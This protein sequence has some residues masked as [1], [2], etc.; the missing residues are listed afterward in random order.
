MRCTS[1]D[2]FHS[3]QC[4]CDKLWVVRRRQKGTWVFTYVYILCCWRP[5]VRKFERKL[6]ILAKQHNVGFHKNLF[7]CFQAV[8]REAKTNGYTWQIYR[9][10]F[11]DFLSNAQWVDPVDLLI[12]ASVLWGN[13]VDLLIRASVCEVTQ[14]TYW[15]DHQFS[16]GTQWTYWSDHQFSEGNRWTYWS[17]RQFSEGT[18][19]TYWSER[20]FCEVTQ[21]TYWSERQLFVDFESILSNRIAGSLNLDTSTSHCTVKST[22]HVSA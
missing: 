21:W 7:V 9:R 14:W 5:T 19:W 6:Q 20:Q 3:E 17:E 10:S 22:L 11:A 18:Q 13:A 1:V 16:Q 15:S 8:S 2:K 4:Y 12:R